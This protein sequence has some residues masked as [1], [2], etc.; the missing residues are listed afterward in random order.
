MP[1]TQ[2]MRPV[3]AASRRPAPRQVRPI[4]VAP[5]A[6][7][8]PNTA[9]APIPAASRPLPARRK[10]AARGKRKTWWL[11]VLGSG[12]V[13]FALAACLILS[14][15]AVMLYGSG[16]IL[17]GVQTAGIAVGNLTEA[18]AS[19]VLASTWASRGVILSDG[20]RS[21]PVDA[22][23]L[24]IS[25]DADATAR[26]AIQY[27]RSGGGIVAAIRALAGPVQVDPILEVNDAAAL[28]GLRA[29][30]PQIDQPP[31]NAGVQVVNGR[32]Q[33]RPARSGRAVDVGLTVAQLD[34]NPARELA[35]GTI[36]LAM[37]PLAPAV[38]DAGALVAA[39][40]ALL[41]DTLDIRAFDPIEDDTQM[42]SVPPEQWGEWLTAV[43]DES[44]PTG[45]DLRLDE[46]ALE[47][48]LSSREAEL[49]T[50]EYVKLD[51]A[52]GALQQAVGGGQTD[53]VV[54]VFHEDT[55]HT[56]QPG[57]T[58]ISIAWDYGVPYPWIQ[59]ANAGIGDSVSVGQT[60]TIPSPDTFMEFEPVY[61]KRIVVSISQ[62]RAWVYENGNLKW[63][64]QVSTGISSSPTW[65]GIYQIIS[66]EPN[67]YAG[68]WDLWMP[69]FMGVYRPVPGAE[70]TNGFHGFPTRGGSQ[71]LWTDSIGTRV[72]YG[73]ILLSNENIQLLYDWAEEGVVVE[74]QA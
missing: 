16:K 44:S 60:I 48:Y 3:R 43:S 51:E 6:Y 56:V 67:A 11:L 4:A 59:D 65:P 31:V 63:E 69:N 55:Q 41:T 50:G 9:P 28:D 7:P 49:E 54:R 36:D 23:L 13:T 12:V 58:I 2:P 62:Q 15:G 27:G 70:L 57:E 39:A 71:L 37:Q 73:C 72:T 19:Q 42:W 53:A 21:F 22:N 1:Y 40:S 25:L 26:A 66:H 52:I 74:I 18:E 17:P 5:A 68:L 34:R 24:G 64:W 46:N 33:E 61:G 35:D 14:L 47:R 29:L 30:A 32:V 10:P 20:S 8:V 45:L 38:T